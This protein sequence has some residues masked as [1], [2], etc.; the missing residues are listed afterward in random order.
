MA[1]DWSGKGLDYLYRRGWIAVR[2]PSLGKTFL[3]MDATKTA[4]QAQMNTVFD[5][6]HKNERY[7]M[8]ISKLTAF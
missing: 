5:Y 8:D 3:D 7:D 4:T 2:N 1:Y 6:I